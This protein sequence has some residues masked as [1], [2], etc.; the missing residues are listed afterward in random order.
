[1]TLDRREYLLGRLQAC[2]ATLAPGVVYTFP[3]GL[4]HRSIQTDLGG[5]CYSKSRTQAR[6]DAD[7]MPFVEILTSSQ[8]ADDVT[9]LDSDLYAATLRVTIMGYVKA[10]DQADSLD[11]VVRQKLDILRADL[12][13]AVEAFPYWTAGGT[14]DAARVVLGP[15]EPVLTSQWTEPAADYPDGYLVLEFAI[16]YL[17]N[18]KTA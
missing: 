11:A 8:G 4:P 9:A 13:T 7:E 2:V 3:D 1:M 18:R 5:R 16:R 10:D 17:F 15:I 6:V 12:I 14:V